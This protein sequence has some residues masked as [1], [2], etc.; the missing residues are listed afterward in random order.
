MRSRNGP[1]TVLRSGF[2]VVK[3]AHT[4]ATLISATDQ[5][6]IAVKSHVMSTSS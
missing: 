4:M 1:K 6:A 5:F 2:N 3:Q